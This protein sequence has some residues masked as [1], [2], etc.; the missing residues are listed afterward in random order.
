MKYLRRIYAGKCLNKAIWK[1]V[2]LCAVF[3]MAGMAAAMHDG[4]DNDGGVNDPV[5]D[6][7]WKS[8]D[9]GAPGVSMDDRI[10][11]GV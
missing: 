5:I 11:Q 3:P 4:N 1:N 9:E 7:K 10:H 2:F 8:M 6:S